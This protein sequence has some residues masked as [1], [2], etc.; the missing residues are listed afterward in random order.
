MLTFPADNL[1]L[2][3]TPRFDKIKIKNALEDKN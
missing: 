1:F 2:I 3:A